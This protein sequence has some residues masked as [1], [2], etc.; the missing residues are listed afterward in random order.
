MSPMNRHPSGL[1]AAV[2]AFSLW[3]VLPLYWKQIDFM[4]APSIVAHRTIWSLVILGIILTARREIPS[5]VAQLRSPAAIG[6]LLVSGSLLAANW[7]LYVWATLNERILEG[8]LGYYLNPFFNMLFGAIWFGER[9]NRPQAIAIALALCGVIIQLPTAGTFPWVAF[10][11]AVTFSLY[12]VVKKRGSAGSRHGLTAESALLTP[13]ALIWLCWQFNSPAAALGG[14]WT[15]ALWLVGAGL[16]TTAPLLFFGYAARNIRLTTLGM[17]QFIGPT[18]QLFIGWK[19][20]GEPMPL[21]SIL[22][23]ALIW[24]AIAVY[25][26]DGIR[27]LKQP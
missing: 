22:S 2:C 3:G 25:S 7:I 23:F 18:V 20:Y 9:H 4:A 1:I 17:V 19:I 24:A 21:A 14:S 6:W 12:A 5:L 11:L 16:A 15:H 27:R 13:I 8:S 26:W 10:T